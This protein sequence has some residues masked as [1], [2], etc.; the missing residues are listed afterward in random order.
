MAHIFNP[1][2]KFGMFVLHNS[3]KYYNII[4][5]DN[6][7]YTCIAWFVASIFMGASITLEKFLYVQKFY[8]N[9][10]KDRWP[11]MYLTDYGEWKNPATII[12]DGLLHDMIPCA[13]WSAIWPVPFVVD[14]VIPVS[15]IAYHNYK[16]RQVV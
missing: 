9:T 16:N 7:R 14:G 2:Q 13:F 8:N 5:I 4:F 12:S 11:R 1:M 3:I 6:Y 10:D 15:V